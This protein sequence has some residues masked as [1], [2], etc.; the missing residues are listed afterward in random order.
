MTAAYDMSARST[1]I[2]RIAGWSLAA[3]LLALPAIAMMA[4]ADGVNWTAS[5]FVFAGVFFAVVGG[6]F[7]VA[8]RASRNLAYRVATVFAVASAFFQIW[9]NLA[10]GIIG[11]EDNPANWTYFAVVLTAISGAVV[12][13][14]DPRNLARAMWL[15]AGLQVAFSILHAVNGTPTPV[16]DAFFAALWIAAGRLWLRAAHQ[17]DHHTATAG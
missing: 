11:N 4:G 2:L 1:R 10:V 16:I 6:I 3:G 9:I 13:L 14:G 8:A 7:E 15:T 17:R 12:A 5:D